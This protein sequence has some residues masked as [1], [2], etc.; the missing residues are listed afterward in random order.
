VWAETLGSGE[1]ERLLAAGELPKLI[2]AAVA[3]EKAAGANQSG[4]DKATLA[5]GLRDE[6][7]ARAFFG[8][9]FTFLAAPA[10]EQSGFDAL[11]AAVAGFSRDAGPAWPLVTLLPFLAQPDRN[12]LLRPKLASLAAHRLGL[13]LRF[14]ADP[15]WVTYSTMLRSGEQLLE[16]LRAIGARDLMD[17]D[18]FLTVVT[19]R[20][21]ARAADASEASDA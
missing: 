15:N 10:P 3:V 18:A 1:G 17:V 13:E 16:K 9:L 7:A 11:I 2:A 4:A 21:P 20:G 8:A 14:A 12:L 19:T 5:T 6:T